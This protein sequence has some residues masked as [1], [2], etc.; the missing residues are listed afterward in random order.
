MTNDQYETLKT[1]NPKYFISGGL[2]DNEDMDNSNHQQSPAYDFIYSDEQA[3]QLA[4]KPEFYQ[5]KLTAEN[6]ADKK[7]ISQKEG[8]NES[9]QIGEVKVI[10]EG[11]QYTEVLPTEAN[12]ESFVD[13]QDS[14]I[15]ALTVKLKIDNQSSEPLSPIDTRLH[16]DE[17]RGTLLSQDM[18][19]P[20][21]PLE[22]KAGDVYEKLEVFLFNKD[23][24]E[25]FKKFNLKVGPFIG[26]EDGEEL[27]KGKTETFTLPR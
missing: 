25:I 13:F 8:I 14:G 11:V 2:A 21:D 15:V 6:L 23:E 19:E 7:M 18:V 9:K 20:N 24:F 4:G 16:I 27:F 17:N 12:A 10:L 3:K 1:I 22:I 5:D 26:P